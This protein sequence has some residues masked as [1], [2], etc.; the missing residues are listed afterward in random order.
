LNYDRD[1]HLYN[2]GIVTWKC[3]GEYRLFFTGITKYEKPSRNI[4]MVNI[5]SPNKKMN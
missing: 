5:I 2:A 1:V 4:K 3:P